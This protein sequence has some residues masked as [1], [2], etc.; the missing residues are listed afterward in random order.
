MEDVKPG[1]WQYGV[2]GKNRMGLLRRSSSLRSPRE[3]GNYEAPVA[4]VSESPHAARPQSCIDGGRM[5]KWLQSL[6]RLQ[7]HPFQKQIPPFVDRTRSMPALQKELTGRSPLFPDLS[8]HGRRNQAPNICP[9]LCETSLSSVG[10][11][12]SHA[13]SERS[14]IVHFKPGPS[15]EKAQFCSLAPV[16]FGWLPTQRH[17]ILT[18]MSNNACHQDNSKCQQKLKSPITPVLLSNPVKLNGSGP[19]DRKPEQSVKTEPVAFKYWRTPEKTSSTHKAS[20]S[21][22]SEGG[23]NGSQAWNPTAKSTRKV[24]TDQSQHGGPRPNNPA[25]KDPTNR[26]RSAPE[27]FSL[28]VPSSGDNGCAPKYSS[29]ISSITLTSRRVTRTSSLPDTS[30]LTQRSLS[31]MTM[32]SKDATDPP[33]AFSSLIMARRKAMVVKVTEQ[34]TNSKTSSDP[35]TTGWP[36]TL[37]PSYDQGCK[38]NDHHVVLRRKATIVKMTEQREHFSQGQPYTTKTPKYRYSYTEGLN[39]TDVRTYDSNFGVSLLANE[40]NVAMANPSCFSREQPDTTTAAK[41]RHSY[42]EGLQ[43]TDSIKNSNSGVSLLA[44]EANVTMANPSRF[45]REQPD[46]K[47]TAKFRHSYTEGLNESDALKYNC[48]SGV[49]LLAN[50]VNVP[51]ANPS[52]FCREQSD[53]TKTAKYRQSYTEGFNETDSLTYSSSSEVS[54]LAN[55]T[56][57]A[58]TNPSCFSGEQPDST[59]T[60]KLHRCSC[61]EGLNGIDGIK[62]DCNSGVSLLGY[63]ANVPMANPFRREQSNSSKTTKLHRHSYT[64]G[65]NG[66]D[67]IKYDCNS[68]VSLLANEVNVLLANP[69]HCSQ[70]QSD[71]TKKTKYRH[72]YTEGL[73]GT[74]AKKYDSRS[75]VSLLANEASLANPSPLNQTFTVSVQPGENKWKSSMSLYLNNP[76]DSST[77]EETNSRKYKPPQRP[78]NCDAS[79]FNHTEL[80]TIAVTHPTFHNKSSPVSQ[81]TNIDLVISSSSEAGRHSASNNDARIPGNEVFQWDRTLQQREETIS[82]IKPLTLLKVPDNSAQ[83]TADAILALNAAAVIANIKLQAQQRQSVQCH[84]SSPE[85]R[86]STLN[87]KTADDRGVNEDSYPSPD[88]DEKTE[89]S[90]M[91][92]HAEFVPFE[93]QDATLESSPAQLSLREALAIRRPDFIQ[94]SQARVRALERRSQERQ[95]LQKPHSSP[96]RTELACIQQQGDSLLKSKNRGFIGKGLQLWTRRNYNKLPEVRKKKEEEKRKKEEEKRKLTSQTNRL[97]AELFKKPVPAASLPTFTCYS[98]AETWE[99]GGMRWRGVLTTAIH[100]GSSRGRL[101]GDGRVASGHR[102]QEDSLPSARGRASW[103]PPEGKGARVGRGVGQSGGALT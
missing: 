96:Q 45:S 73:N 94:R 41:Y 33:N 76:T 25:L 92:P 9:S 70:E 54:L 19:S 87:T 88:T 44:N 57:V 66:T 35:S 38:E 28:R 10:S 12:K 61:T 65:L 30:R 50:E 100:Q 74:D 95:A 31:P 55:E 48:N 85:Q 23:R 93:S 69:S 47:T 22:S 99:G 3:Q 20:G 46:T 63:E 17:V 2:A 14:D 27:S 97:R 34:L 36:I 49:S 15:A 86:Q 21:V 62:Y 51:L 24:D 89:T 60:A 102:E 59:E 42:T 82:G 26:R 75:G 80:D 18:E 79:L 16:R 101:P 77:A 90:S 83:L 71:K 37:T 39:R 52:Y 84:N 6:E 72:S 56:K 29:S 40:A 11:M 5:D 64:E 43:K 81:K 53:T 91:C 58:M 67:A 98:G 4:Q 8:S 32:M 13:R 7:A 103:C 78:L 1:G 68:G